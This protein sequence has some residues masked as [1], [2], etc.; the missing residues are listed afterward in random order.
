MKKR[1]VSL[2]LLPLLLIQYSFGQQPAGKS[3]F[4]DYEA[5]NENT[6]AL[7]I[8]C[9]NDPILNPGDELTLEMWV[10]AYTFG[11]NRKVL[12][13]IDSQG[14]SF[15]NGYVMGFQNLNVYTEIWNP[16][17]QV[18]PYAGSGPMVVDSGFV[19]LATTYSATTGKMQ[20]YINGVLVGEIQIFPANPI[21]PNDAEFMIGAAPWDPFAYQ[22]YGALDEVRVWNVARTQAQIKDYMFKELSGSEEGLVAYYNFN[23][24][25]GITVPDM[26]GNNNTGTLQNGDDPSWS[27][28]TS[29]APVGGIHMYE[30]SEPVAAWSGKTGNEFNYAV[31][32]NGLSVIAE[33]GRKEFWKYVLFA[34]NDLQGISSSDAPSGQHTDFAR[35]HREWNLQQSGNPS[36]SVFLNINQAAGNGETLPTGAEPNHYA[37]LYRTHTDTNFEAIA[38][39]NQVF[40]E[41]LIFNDLVLS[42]GY[43]ALGYSSSSF[44]LHLN[45]PEFSMIPR[46]EVFPNPATD[47]LFISNAANQKVVIA[48][49]QGRILMEIYPGSEKEQ[50][51]TRLLP[52]GF[53]TL[54]VFRQHNRSTHKLIIN[55]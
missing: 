34:H 9:G 39:P 44:D 17:L 55:K 5:W 54:T 7:H 1:C 32:Q 47:Y 53:Y 29:Y 12:G 16:T 25:E 27:W 51:S 36:K 24:A 26:S 22:F 30:L 35:T 41:N 23:T 20:D 15:D 6:P 40:H 43:Y 52:A 8:L 2:F 13:K 46:V 11:E 31:T 28:A 19:H 49:L 45:T 10:R 3:W 48:D 18:I 50:I 21:A 37:L 38:F 33:I 14:D 4:I 42:D